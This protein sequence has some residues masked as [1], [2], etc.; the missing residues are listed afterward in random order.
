MIAE[1]GE[2]EA[3]LV[4]EIDGEQVM[5]GRDR[6]ANPRVDLAP[7]A[8]S[9]AD[10]RAQP[11]PVDRIAAFVEPVIREVE[12]APWRRPRVLEHRVHRGERSGLQVR[13]VE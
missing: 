11:V 6:R 13:H 4:D 2:P 7:F 10:R 12:V 3:V 8:R 5:P 9:R 1:L